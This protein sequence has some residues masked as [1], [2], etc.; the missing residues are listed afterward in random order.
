MTNLEKEKV[1]EMRRYGSSYSQISKA[2]GIS[3]NT[4]KSFCRRNGLGSTYG[5][6]RRTEDGIVCRQ[7]GSPLKQSS[8]MK[9]KRF[10]SDQCRMNWWNSHPEAVSRKAF[11]TFHCPVCGCEFE[12]YGNRNRKYCSRACYGQSR[13]LAH[14]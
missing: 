4:V 8:G 5:D 2:L 3:E 1:M 11:Y 7:C 14:E 10:C 13:V 9:M 6:Q 12:S